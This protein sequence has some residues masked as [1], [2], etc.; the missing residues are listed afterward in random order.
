[1]LKHFAWK[2]IAPVCFAEAKLKR[3]ALGVRTE[4]RSTV[5]P[6]QRDPCPVPGHS[7]ST[8]GVEKNG[9]AKSGGLGRAHAAKSWYRRSAL[10]PAL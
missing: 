2:E 1:M 8:N 5:T 7:G 3:V 9:V 6:D 4:S 10:V